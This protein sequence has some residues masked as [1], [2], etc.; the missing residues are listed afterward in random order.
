MDKQ[1]W[2]R[3][4]RVRAKTS[5]FVLFI[6]PR[7]TGKDLSVIQKQLILKN[8]LDLLYSHLRWR[9][10]CHLLWITYLFTSS[11]QG[12]AS[13]HPGF[14]KPNTPY[15]HTDLFLYSS[16]LYGT[17]TPNRIKYQWWSQTQPAGIWYTAGTP[18]HPWSRGAHK[19]SR[20]FRLTKNRELPKGAFPQPFPGW[21]ES[22]LPQSWQAEQSIAEKQPNST[23]FHYSPFHFNLHTKTWDIWTREN[24]VYVWG[25][26]AGVLEVKVAK[27]FLLVYL[28]KENCRIQKLAHEAMLIWA[29]VTWNWENVSQKVKGSRNLKLSSSKEEN[30]KE[31]KKRECSSRRKVNWLSCVHRDRSRQ[32]A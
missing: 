2:A 25:E 1:K 29:A 32:A 4:K 6:R 13:S 8:K 11:A 12:H 17:R 7:W 14:V 5:V 10:K 31:K 15:F 19:S 28:G 23:M 18:G 22:S 26:A 16:L 30:K 27:V 9:I 21:L 3:S 24:G 20:Y